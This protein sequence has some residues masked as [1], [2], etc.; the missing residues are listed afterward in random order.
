MTAFSSLC[1]WLF[2]Y[3]KAHWSNWNKLTNSKEV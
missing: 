1:P 3:L 2:S